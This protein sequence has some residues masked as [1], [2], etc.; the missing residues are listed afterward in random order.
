M[1]LSAFPSEELMAELTAK[2]FLEVGAIFV[3][4]F[5]RDGARE[6]WIELGQLV[7]SIKD[8]GKRIGVVTR[9]CKPGYLRS[10]SDFVLEVYFEGDHLPIPMKPWEVLP[11][12]SENIKN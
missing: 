3:S 6:G 4:A 7:E 1:F 12:R 2:M 8:S 9:I 11:V 10:S 5:S